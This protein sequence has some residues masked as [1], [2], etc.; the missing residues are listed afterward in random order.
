MAAAASEYER[1]G[2][3]DGVVRLVDSFYDHMDTLPAAR[4]I[5]AL[6][7]DDQSADR[8]KLTAFL[9][10]WMGGPKLY[11]HRA[12]ATELHRRHRHLPV[13]TD[14]RDA[15]L[16]CM[17]AALEETVDEEA[18]RT[19][20]KLRFTAVAGRVVNEEGEAKGGCPRHG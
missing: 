10:G 12:N 4:T 3:H 13:D 20:L 2:G 18:L 19:R 11:W 6:H 1:I 9:S 17:S 15:W 16:L 5:R 14:A 7:D 8:H